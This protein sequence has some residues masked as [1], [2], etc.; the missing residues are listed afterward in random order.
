MFFFPNL[1]PH[2]LIFNDPA[3]I[4]AISVPTFTLLFFYL[5]S[6]QILA[7]TSIILNNLNTLN[8]KVVN[9]MTNLVILF[10]IMANNIYN[11]NYSIDIINTDF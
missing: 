4:N 7:Y 11:L 3:N 2:N 10:V 9:L 1:S 6:L 5:N 8:S